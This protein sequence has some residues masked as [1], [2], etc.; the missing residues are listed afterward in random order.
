MLFALKE[1]DPF[2]HTPNRDLQKCFAYAANIQEVEGK[3]LNENF[4]LLKAQRECVKNLFLFVP[5]A[6][7][8]HVVGAVLCFCMGCITI[9]SFR[10]P[11]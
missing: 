11:T 1:K 5:Q 8:E 10:L 6:F 9:F 7:I 3:I 2:E 4:I